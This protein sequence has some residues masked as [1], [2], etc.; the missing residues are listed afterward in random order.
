[1]WF[2][3]CVPE[4]EG[5]GLMSDGA[6]NTEMF[7]LESGTSYS[8]RA[9]LAAV[10]MDPDLPGPSNDENSPTEEQQQQETELFSVPSLSPTS[11][12]G[13]PV[14]TTEA[15]PAHSLHEGSWNP[16]GILNLLNKDGGLYHKEQQQTEFSRV[17]T[18]APST[19]RTED[20]ASDS[21]LN[22]SV[23]LCSAT[24]SLAHA[25]ATAD[26]QDHTQR[27]ARNRTFV[28]SIIVT[29]K[30]NRRPSHTHICDKIAREKRAYFSSS[31]STP[32]MVAN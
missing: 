29:N 1:M 25:R 11:A 32:T 5:S 26:P 31:E 19:S 17:L 3:S 28:D 8:V 6:F 30:C 9:I 23:L 18:T 21:S 15:I 10:D 24:L 4:V 27:A 14:H 22:I 7:K 13:D 16:D 2:S 12:I 20:Q